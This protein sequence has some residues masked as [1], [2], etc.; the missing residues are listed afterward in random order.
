MQAITSTKSTTAINSISKLWFVIVGSLLF[1]FLFWHEKIAVNATLFFIFV[2]IAITHFYSKAWHNKRVKWLLLA[3]IFSLTMVIWHNTALSKLAFI[4]ALFLMAAYS[5]Y[6]HNS[7]LYASGSVLQSF[8]FFFPSF[9]NSVKSL[10]FIRKRKTGIGKKITLAIFPVLILI[11]FLTFY[12]SANKVFADLLERIVIK[13]QLVFCHLFDWIEPQRL[14]FLCFG[15]WICGGLLVRYLKAPLEK[16]EAD[17][18]D[19]LVRK[20]KTKYAKGFVAEFPKVFLG[21]FATRTMALKN[22]YISGIICLA[23]LNILLLLVN[24]TDILY[25][26]FSFKYTPD[27]DLTKFVHEGAEL[28]VA[29]IMSAMLVVLF[30]FRGNLNFFSK[31]K[32]LKIVAYI[33]IAQNAILAASVCVRNIYY[34]QHWGLA[35]KRV[36]LFIY[37]FLVIIGLISIVIKIQKRKSSYYLWRVNAMIAF[38]VLILSC[39]VDWD[40]L[41]PIIILKGKILFLVMLGLSFKW[42]T[43][44]YRC[45]NNTSLGFVLPINKIQT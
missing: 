45:W 35:Y 39:C 29:S 7:L 14:L 34:I 30:F 31:N 28:L 13:F 38:A 20:K 44:F 40:Y 32:Y 33:W 4:T 25:V 36:G 21:K 27:M 37:I 43:V 8:L 5:Q 19:F 41:L 3:A 10:G 42:M 11:V 6:T 26:W 18:T 22:E 1:N 16:K 12:L 23:L 17:K 15:L 9:F 24:T 2:I